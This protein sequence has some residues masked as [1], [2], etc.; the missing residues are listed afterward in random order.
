MRGTFITPELSGAVDPAAVDGKAE[1]FI[2][3]EN[4]DVLYDSFIL[5]RF[6]R[7]L[8][9]REHLIDIVKATTGLELTDDEL[10]ETAKRI[11]TQTRI[12]NVREGV[13]KKD[14]TLP[15]MFFKKPLAPGGKTITKEEL[16]KMV[17]EYYSLHGWDEEGVPPEKN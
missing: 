7:H 6:M 1:M 13:T 16:S 12:F 5:C 15:E 4:N 9:E 2:R 17:A 14:D 10:E 3:Y 8:I 11:T